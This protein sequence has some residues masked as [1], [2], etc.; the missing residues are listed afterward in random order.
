MLLFIDDAM[1][2]ADE[3]ILKYTSEA[4]EIFKEW[5]ALRET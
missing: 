4:L 5:K 3:Y 2:H 1:R